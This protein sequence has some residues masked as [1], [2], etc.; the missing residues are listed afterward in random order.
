MEAERWHIGVSVCGQF[1]V[2]VSEQFLGGPLIHTVANTEDLKGLSE[3]VE[4]AP[5]GRARPLA[6]CRCV[7]A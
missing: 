1:G 3:G 7:E 2:T 5:R 4:N 6:R